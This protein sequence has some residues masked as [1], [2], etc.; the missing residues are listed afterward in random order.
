MFVC[1][2]ICLEAVA[3]K[4][5]VKRVF[6]EISQNSQGN[7]CVSL[8]LIKLEAEAC[9]FIIK[10]LWHRF[11]LVNFAKFRR[12]SFLREHFRWLLL[13]VHVR[14][15]WVWKPQ[16]CDEPNISFSIVVS[17]IIWYHIIIHYFHWWSLGIILISKDI[18]KKQLQSYILF[19]EAGIFY[20]FAKF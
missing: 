3:P 9:N 17:Q 5:S 7:T 10:R 16:F 8:F 1:D 19:H 15:Q 6:F 12:T 2:N 18:I 20:F 14:F 4:C 11:F 13:C